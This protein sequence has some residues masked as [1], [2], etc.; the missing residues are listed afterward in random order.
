[1]TRHH[2]I[3]NAAQDVAGDCFWDRIDPTP[4]QVVAT[5]AAKTRLDLN[6]HERLVAWQ[7]YRERFVD[8]EIGS[9]HC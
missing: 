5:V 6:D 7:A 3:V 2:E 4:E 1:M 9:I 8:W